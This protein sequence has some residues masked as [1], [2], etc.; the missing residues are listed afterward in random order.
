[1]HFLDVDNLLNDSIVYVSTEFID[2]A[3][4]NLKLEDG[5]VADQGN[6]NICLRCNFD[7]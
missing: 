4:K 7:H 6:C 2:G 3:S 5:N 1:M